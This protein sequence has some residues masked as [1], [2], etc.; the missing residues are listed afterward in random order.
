[1][2]WIRFQDG[3]WQANT[4]ESLDAVRIPEINADEADYLMATQDLP[5]TQNTLWLLYMTYKRGNDVGYLDDPK[6]ARVDGISRGTY[7]NG[8]PVKTI[9][10]DK[11]IL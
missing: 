1:M 9:K 2:L 5:G 11:D 10:T 8:K 6:N 3:K 4:Y 7:I